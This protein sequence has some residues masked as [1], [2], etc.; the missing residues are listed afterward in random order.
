M[1][2]LQNVFDLFITEI[3]AIATKSGLEVCF[4]IDTEHE[5]KAF[6]VSILEHDCPFISIYLFRLGVDRATE[7]AMYNRENYDLFNIGSLIWMEYEEERIFP[8]DHFCDSVIFYR[9]TP[10]H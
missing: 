10:L 1:S 2:E 7:V 5:V 6:E 8:M 9:E 3:S 4:K